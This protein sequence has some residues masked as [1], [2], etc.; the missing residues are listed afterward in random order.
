MKRKRQKAREDRAPAGPSPGNVRRRWWIAGA[1]IVILGLV[2]GGAILA[3]RALRPPN[4]ILITLDTTR[5]DHLGCYGQPNAGTS[6]LDRLA[7]EGALFLNCTT[8]VPLTL[9][10]HASLMTGVYPFVHGI[11]DN[12]GF[13]L[14]PDR[15]TLAEALKS[16]GYAT[17]AQIAA[18]VLNRDYGLNRGFDVYRDMHQRSLA[19]GD[20][21]DEM[22]VE[23]K[24]SDI[25][26]AAIQFIQ[27]HRSGP[28][29]LWTHWFDP[30][31]PYEA[32]ASLAAA[33]SDP[34]QAEIAY[35]DQQIGRLLAALQAE[36]LSKRT[37]LI[38]VGDHGEGREQHQEHTHGSFL[39]DST[40]SVPL[41]VW[42][43]GRVPAG[44][45]VAAQVRTIDVAATVLNLLSLPA[46]RDTQGQS[47]V[48]VM[49]APA[50][51]PRIAA[52]SETFHP[53]Y[54]YGYSQLRS[55]REDGWKLI[56]APRPEL[57]HV[58]ADPGETTNLADQEPGRVDDM[59]RKLQR[60][61]A[62]AR[63]DARAAPVA[64]ASSA[65]AALESL[66]YIG[67]E[68]SEDR[69]SNTPELDRF[70]PQGP[71]PMDHA[72][73]IQSIGLAAERLTQGRTAE[74]EQV[75]R[76]LVAEE[77]PE[78]PAPFRAY[79]L[80]GR[81]LA[82]QNRHAEAVEAY[83]HALA[84][85]PSDA[86]TLTDLGN[87]LASLAKWDDAIAAYSAAIECKPPLSRSYLNLSMVL[88]RLDRQ[89]D[90]LS[91]ATAA[92]QLD[93]GSA[94]AHANLGTVYSKLGRRQ[95]ALAEFRKAVQISPR[96][97]TY[98]KFLQQVGG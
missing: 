90:A 32:P 52:Y 54:T 59:R 80:L 24:A 7:S 65:T 36:G 6:N 11:R 42:A 18:T 26:D 64:V 94:K 53:R 79:L 56:H 55:L 30:H 87:S 22:A 16:A 72:R 76:E 17:G 86:A 47:L 41:I 2:A 92:V 10:S 68:S 89:T 31:D 34:Y 12:G 20:E 37:I 4:V 71:N 3:R 83:R 60:L 35:V 57:Y 43:P 98:Q 28:F 29:F 27:E 23:R 61:L 63:A 49:S 14:S 46:L 8:A 1:G 66:G 9:P 95:E 88:Q 91:Y 75:L 45:R 84:Q 38:V 93:P 85:N 5:A 50:A 25:C 58:A 13:V 67:A 33:Y 82:K 78:Q 15:Q 96:N 73:D 81:A 51:D 21:A 48:S 19:A 40:L 74:A 62:N 97:P 77:S 70:T 39:Y 44:G 69:N